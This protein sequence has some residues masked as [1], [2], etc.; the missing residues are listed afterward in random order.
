MRHLTRF[1]PRQA[2]GRGAVS[3]PAVRFDAHGAS[4][5]DD[6]WD[7]LTQDSRRPAAARHHA[8][9]RLDPVGN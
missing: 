1:P 4:P 7:T 5:F 9:P 2:A 6:G 8:D 3:N